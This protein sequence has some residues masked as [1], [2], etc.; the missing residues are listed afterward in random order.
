MPS[1][2]VVFA[3]STFGS[4]GPEAQSFLA[5]MAQRAGGL[6]RALAAES[7]WAASSFV[8]FARMALSCAARRGLAEH[9]LRAWRRDREA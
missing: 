9:V 5:E 6:P 3:V 2:L 7:S 1:P 4:F 8:P